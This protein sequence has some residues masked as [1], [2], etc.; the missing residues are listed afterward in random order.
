MPS[1]TYI[2]IPGNFATR[3]RVIS[4]RQAYTQPVRAQQQSLHSA[5]SSPSVPIAIKRLVILAMR[6]SSVYLISECKTFDKNENHERN[7]R[8]LSDQPARL[9]II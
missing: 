4:I 3:L 2:R 8:H 6:N 9:I 7:G 5:S 1:R